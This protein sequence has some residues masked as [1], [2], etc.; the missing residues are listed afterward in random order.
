MTTPTALIDAYLDEQLDD[1]GVAELQGWLRADPQNLREFLRLT[2]IHRE[3]RREYLNAAARTGY[4]EG[5]AKDRPSARLVRPSSRRLSLRRPGRRA[6]WQW[7]GLAVAACLL[8]TVTIVLT[9]SSSPTGE[10]VVVSAG[11]ATVLRS[12]QTIQLFAGDQLRAADVLRTGE[13]RAT[14][15]FPDGTMLTLAPEGEIAFTALGGASVGK[16]L[17]IA[18][19]RLHADV[20]PQPSGHPLVIRAPTAVATVIGTAFDLATTPAQTRLDVEH[21]RVRLQRADL[22]ANVEVSAGEY[23]VAAPDQVL[24]VRKQGGF[25]GDLP[26]HVGGAKH[27]QLVGADG[28]RFV[29]KGAQHY[30]INFNSQLGAPIDVQVSAERALYQRAFD[31]R[32][33]QLDAMKACGINTVRIFVG[34]QVALDAN[35]GYRT[36]SEGY[37]GLTGYIQR[38]ATYADDARSRGF[39][40]IFCAY[41]DGSWPDDAH[42]AQYEQFFSALVPTLRDNGNV[43]YE[44]SHLPEVDDHEWSRLSK[45]SITL[46]RALGYQGPLIV[47]LNHFSN[48]WYEPEVEQVARQDPQLVFSLGFAR[49]VGWERTAE[50][51][52]HGSDHPVIL[53]ALTREVNGDVGETEAIAAASAMRDL[54]ERGQAIGVI[55]HGWNVRDGK[56]PLRGNGMTDDD[57]ARTPNSWGVGYR[58]QFS[59]RLPNWLPATSA[60]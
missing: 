56:A 36:R 8:V 29:M 49:W 43:L 37:G 13:T 19:G 15:T 32:L 54:V 50:F 7:V 55:A 44:L 17:Q 38:L 1:A 30:V 16:E 14:V 12:E 10:R 57:G 60:P 27:N 39:Q 40:V 2:A 53:G 52:R 47:G 59:G 11:K 42:W 3:L 41:G 25:P 24:V 18:H 6:N 48:W 35:N 4:A 9:H 51:L 33:A 23:A 28:K 34:P 5:A 58:D 21:G 31:E 46:F 22:V 26:L 20:A 45:R